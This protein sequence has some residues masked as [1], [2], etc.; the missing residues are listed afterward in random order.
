MGDLKGGVKK[1]K[2]CFP[3][4]SR[5][6]LRG[7]RKYKQ[8]KKDYKEYYQEYFEEIINKGK[9][10]TEQAYRTDLENF[11]NKIKPEQIT[12]EQEPHREKEFGAPDFCIE[13][14]GAI[15]GYI[16]TKKPGESLSK[17][18]NSNQI[19]R[20]LKISDNFILTNYHEFMLFK[21]GEITPFKRSALFFDADFGNKKSKIENE[22]LEQT[23]KLFSNFFA[24]TPANINDSEKLAVYLANRAKE[25]KSFIF[26]VL[27][28]AEKNNFYYKING[29][30][31]TFKKI[32]VKD[33]K[34]DEFA[35]AY[36]QTVVYSFLLARL[37]SKSKITLFESSSFIPSSF[38]VI[39]ELFEFIAPSYSQ[40]AEFKWI[41]KEIIDIVNNIAP[42]L[43]K[44]LSFKQNEEK[45]HADPYIYF[46]ETFLKEFDPEKRKSKG[47]YYTPSQVV[48][49]IIRSID[50]ILYK[51]FGITKGFADTSVTVLDFATGTGTFLLYIFQLVLE[52]IR[53]KEAG[54]LNAVVSEHI[55]KNF[56]GFEY[57]ISPYAV[58]HLKLSQ[59]LKDNGYNFKEG[60]E[61]KIYLTDTLDDSELKTQ[62]IFPVISEEGKKANEL[63]TKKE[64]LVITGNP[65]YSNRSTGQKIESLMTDYKPKGEKKLNL[66]DD[67]IKFIRFAH[68]K[69]EKTKKGV[70]GIITNNSFLNGLTHRKMREKL[71]KDF[72]EVYILN[73]H[74]NS[75]IGEASHDGGIDENVF[76]IMQ[77]VS[78]SIFVKKDISKNQKRRL[79]YYDL[80]GRREY[81]YDFLKTNDIETVKWE[82]IDYEGFNK[83]FKKT[84]WGKN[85]F[86]EN[87]SFFVPSGSKGMSDYGCF[88]GITEIFKEYN[89]G[90]QTKR[91]NL[92]IQFYKDEIKQVIKD[93]KDLS[94]EDI[95]RKYKLSRDSSGW[96]FQNAKQVL[97]KSN[98]DE[99]NIKKIL[100]R[101]FDIRYTY[102]TKEQGFLGRPRYKTMRCLLTGDNLGLIFSRICKNKIFDY[103]QIT[104]TLIDIAVNGKNTGSETYIAP[105]Y[106]YNAPD[107]I[108][109]KSK[110][111]GTKLVKNGKSISEKQVNFTEE[112]QNFIKKKYEPENPTPEEIL[113]YIYAI[114]HS[115]TYREKYLEFLKIDFP[116]I[117][118]VD[119]FDKFMELS[120]IGGELIEH[121]L[122]RKE[123]PDDK[124]SFSIQGS[125]IVEKIRFFKDKT[126]ETGSIFINDKQFFG[127]ASVKAWDFCIG[128]YQVLDKWLKSRKGRILSLE[129]KRIFTKIIDILDFTVTR[130]Q[131]IEKITSDI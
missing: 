10:K 52:K 129:E 26:E 24:S 21:D 90:I 11:L 9:D 33:L 58:A 48:S 17:I 41:I 61:L 109:E 46:Y 83:N 1:D 108:E 67:Y 36:A 50:K 13:K 127:N 37:K 39:K 35:D 115:P 88:W 69:M 31:E 72:D 92:T 116:R 59:F 64:I 15:I 81:K 71:L 105:L 12:I 30:Y 44:S 125:D 91:D 74:G 19:K 54:N 97:T 6:E 124:I 120:D 43:Y 40:S 131:D 104:N 18:Y 51:T 47:V 96:N 38:K 112:F 76:D 8:M 128:G 70:I 60:E 78:I 110:D 100:Y 16:E 63:K 14:E 87:L 34:K 55:L 98:F 79:F 82:R 27:K 73:L 84:R 3:L 89:S 86:K 62:E 95:R 7:S 103:G 53:I 29:L 106:I 93:V 66:N 114:M 4:P 111:N 45:E 77:G 75:R 56:Y 49:F 32:L 117:P 126:S 113:G 107:F 22:N 5:G 118:F 20:Y 25:L 101:P 130:M 123:Y 94:E 28:K 99:S 121:H 102:F 42:E 80:Y 68:N 119:D 23:D 57:L 122:M 2:T 85:R 65:P